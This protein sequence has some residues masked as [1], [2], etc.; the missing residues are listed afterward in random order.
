MLRL[1]WVGE[2]KSELGK[3]SQCSLYVYAPN[4]A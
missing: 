2:F 3:F 4:N 1:D